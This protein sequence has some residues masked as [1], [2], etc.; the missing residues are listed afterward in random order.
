MCVLRQRFWK[1]RQRKIRDV[2]RFFLNALRAEKRPGIQELDSGQWLVKM[3]RAHKRGENLFSPIRPPCMDPGSCHPHLPNCQIISGPA[4]G[5][6]AAPQLLG[7]SIAQADPAAITLLFPIADERRKNHCSGQP[8]SVGLR[9]G[10][11]GCRPRR[12]GPC[13]A[14]RRVTVQVLPT[15]PEAGWQ[16]EA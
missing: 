15:Q 13:A 7:I 14:G 9:R 12:G 11:R 4:A 2:S 10:R 6:G 16:A 3:N 1:D 8:G 5:P